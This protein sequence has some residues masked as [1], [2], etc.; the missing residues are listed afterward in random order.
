MLDNMQFAIGRGLAIAKADTA[1][2]AKMASQA[3]R[4]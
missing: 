2:F 4:K 1:G 3:F